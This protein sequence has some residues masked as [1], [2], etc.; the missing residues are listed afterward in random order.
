[1][2]TRERNCGGV[3]GEGERQGGWTGAE[4]TGL[5]FC[6]FFTFVILLFR[7]ASA[8][9][10]TNPAKYTKYTPQVLEAMLNKFFDEEIN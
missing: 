3:R 10:S 5:I 2:R 1:M 9:F 8:D 6:L 7:F 4:A